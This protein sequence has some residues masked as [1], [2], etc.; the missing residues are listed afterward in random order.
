VRRTCGPNWWTRSG[1]AAATL[2]SVWVRIP[3]PKNQD[4]RRRRLT[5]PE[6]LRAHGVDRAHGPW[7]QALRQ[8]VV[9][10]YHRFAAGRLRWRTDDDGGLPPSS[11]AIVSPYDP[12]ARYARGGRPPAGRNSSPISPRP[13]RPA[14]PTWS[15]TWPPRTTPR[16]CLASTPA[17]LTAEHLVEGGYTSLVH[18]EQA[19]RTAS[20][21]SHRAVTRQSH[22]PAPPERRL[23]PGRLPHRLR[24]LASGL[25]PGPG[26]QPTRSLPD[27]L[28]HHCAA[29]RSEVRQA[30][31]SPAQSARPP[32]ESS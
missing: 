31:A 18:L 2:R 29:D 9:Q 13:A 7:V 30:S 23:R 4:Q 28:A 19:A 10:N 17:W 22:P 12:T 3:R 16:P 26:Q 1:D 6:H 11:L 24:P 5:V 27:F 21:H 8:I 25:P 20:G 14:A 15:Q 32:T